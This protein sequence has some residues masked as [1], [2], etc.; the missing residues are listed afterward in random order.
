[1]KSFHQVLS[2]MKEKRKAPN[3]AFFFILYSFDGNCAVSKPAFIK[4]SFAS[5]M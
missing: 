1:M 4:T 5:L 3:G 2:T